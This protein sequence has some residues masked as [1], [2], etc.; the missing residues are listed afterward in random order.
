MYLMRI[1]CQECIRNSYNSVTKQITQ[2]KNKDLS[3]HFYKQD[4]WMASTHVN[5]S[6]T[7][8]VK[9]ETQIKTTVRQHRTSLRMAV[10]TNTYNTRL[11]W[12]CWE[13]ETNMHLLGLLETIWQILNV[14]N[15]KFPYDS[16]VAFLGL[17]PQA[18]ETYVHTK[19]CTQVFI[20]L[21]WKQPECPSVD[22]WMNITCISTQQKTIWQ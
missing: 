5:R 21:L 16:A 6:S 4:A 8:L 12:G 20:W 10:I 22:L 1:L 3:R 15:A 18:L 13:T 2:I 19:T 11:S 7:S 17:Y 14:L 9:R